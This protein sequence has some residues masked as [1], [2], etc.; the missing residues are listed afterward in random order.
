MSVSLGG[1]GRSKGGRSTAPLCRTDQRCL[2]GSKYALASSP[3]SAKSDLS[4][5]QPAICTS[6]LSADRPLDGHGDA[7]TG[8]NAAGDLYR[9]PEI[10]IS[11][12]LLK[13]RAHGRIVLE[14]A[15]LIAQ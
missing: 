11:G 6:A 15:Q 8:E 2:V 4:A 3:I 13:Q 5:P 9:A 1:T 10:V 7:V 12:G 14:H